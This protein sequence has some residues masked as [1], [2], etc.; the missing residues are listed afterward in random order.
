[1]RRVSIAAF[2]VVCPDIEC[3]SPSIPPAFNAGFFLRP[4]LQNLQIKEP[5]MIKNALFCPKSHFFLA[6]IG[7]N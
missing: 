4:L 7:K 5:I 3:R 6:Y 2:L 1:M